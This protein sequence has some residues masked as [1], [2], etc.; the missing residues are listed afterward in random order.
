M[1]FNLFTYGTLLKGN[2]NDFYLSTSKYVGDGKLNGIKLF[3]YINSQT[4]QS[5]YPVALE[6]ENGSELLGE[7]Y[8]VPDAM[9]P[10]LEKL[11]GTPTLYT[12]ETRNVTLADGSTVQC[13][14][15]IG[16]PSTWKNVDML[17]DYPMEHKYVQYQYELAK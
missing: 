15:Y 16:N 10:Y 7:V 2:P 5:L 1:S 8:K 17:I 12:R 4:L 6:T 9:L 3:D 14:V 13:F 11:E